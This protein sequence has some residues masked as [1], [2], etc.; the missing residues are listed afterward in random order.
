MFTAIRSLAE[1]WLFQLKDS[2]PGEIV[3][4]MRRVLLT[5]PDLVIKDPAGRHPT[6]RWTLDANDWHLAVT[7]Q[8]LN[9]GDRIRTDS[10]S[11]AT[12]QLS[13]RSTIRVNQLTTMEIQPPVPPARHRFSLRG[14]ALFFLDENRSVYLQSCQWHTWITH[15]NA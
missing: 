3:L 6:R 8:V 13:D 11:R 12:L 1:R 15:Y 4:V 10:D 9:P 2:E 14:G 5:R 7:N